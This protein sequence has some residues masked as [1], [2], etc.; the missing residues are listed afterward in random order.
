MSNNKIIVMVGTSPVGRGGIASVVQGYEAAGLLAKWQVRYLTTHIQKSGL[1]KLWTALSAIGQLLGLLL[2]RRVALVHVHMSTGASTWR[3]S[4]FIVSSLAFQVPCLIHMHGGDYVQFFN[5]HCNRTK[6]RFIRWLLTQAKAVIVLSPGWRA[7][8]GAIAPDAKTTVIYN[9]VALPRFEQARPI[10]RAGG[11]CSIL[12]LGRISEAKGAFDL[13]RA[14]ALV[15][16]DFKLTLCGPGDIERATELVTELKLNSKVEFAGWVAGA[17]KDQLLANANIFV[18]PSHYEGVPMAILEAMAW[19][20]PIVATAVGGIPDVV[21]DGVEGL[22]VKPEDV[23]GLA[24]ALNTLLI[25]TQ[26]GLEMGAA[27][28]R[29]IEQQYSQAV[30]LPQLEQLWLSAGAKAP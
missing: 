26:S 4:I 15:Q 9:S 11:T 30:L 27:G 12:F 5:N 8:I 10:G 3:K 6:Q 24:I 29:K 23:D 7:D 25:D 18:L 17:A 19:A 21:S 13:I 20:L 1:S 28:R 16:G 14:A 2:A 22:L